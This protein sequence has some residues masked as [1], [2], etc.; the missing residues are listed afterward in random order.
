MQPRRGP[1][2]DL[3]AAGALFLLAF[4]ARLALLH[5]APYGDEAAHYTEARSLGGNLNVFWMGPDVPFTLGALVAGRPLFALLHAPGTWLGFEGFRTLGLSYAALLAPVLYGLL[6]SLRCHLAIAASAGAAVA[7]LPA[8]VVWGSRVF[9]DSLMALLFVAGLWAWSARKPAL[10]AALLVASAWTKETAIAPVAVLAIVTWAGAVRSRRASG[11]PWGPAFRPM[12]PDGWLVAAAAA[13]PLGLAAGLL[14]VAKLPGWVFGGTV[15]PILER[16]PLSSLFLLPLLVAACLPRARLVAVPGLAVLGFYA[17]FVT[18]RGGLVQAW[19][20]ILPATLALAS[21]AVAV[22]ACIKRGRG[23]RVAGFGMAAM[24]LLTVALGV[25]GATGPAA[26]FAHPLHAEDEPGLAASIRFVQAESPSE[27]AAAAFQ[28]S[29]RPA[30]VFE[31][32]PAWFFIDYPL[33]GLHNTTFVYTVSMPDGTIPVARIAHAIEGSDLTWMQSW[34]MTFQK[35]VRATYADCVRFE[36]GLLTAFAG[37]QCPGRAA[38][39]A[40]RYAV[41]RG[42]TP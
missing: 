4:A 28:R 20:A 22:D 9:P 34:N 42:S 3:V 19:Y 1:L 36:A 16:M 17:A 14:V 27:R 30:T 8:F 31:V 39:L 18:L 23:L 2:A 6:R 11:E 29:V 41:A 33:G 24:L 13:A 37:K 12:S 26:A 10:A 15:W 32:D 21:A 5:A 7:L 25:V 35:A 40:E 38:A